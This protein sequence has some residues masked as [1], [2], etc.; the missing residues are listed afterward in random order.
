MLVL[1]RI[2]VGQKFICTKNVWS[3]NQPAWEVGQ[4][5]KF[6]GYANGNRKNR[7]FSAHPNFGMSANHAKGQAETSLTL[8]E[9]SDYLQP[10][11]E[12]VSIDQKKE[13]AMIWGKAFGIEIDSL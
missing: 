11:T 2:K 5:Y 13:I 7:V 3:F 6:L 8:I 1:K 9:L 4:V 12:P 10:H